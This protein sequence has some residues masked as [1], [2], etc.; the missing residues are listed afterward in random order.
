MVSPTTRT[1][2]YLNIQKAWS[3]NFSLSEQAAQDQRVSQAAA[4][5]DLPRSCGAVSNVFQGTWQHTYA[6]LIS[7]N[8]MTRGDKRLELCPHF[9]VHFSSPLSLLHFLFH[10]CSVV[11]CCISFPP[12]I[13]LYELAEFFTQLL[14]WDQWSTLGTEQNI[15]PG[16]RGRHN[17]LQQSPP[18]QFW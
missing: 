9:P 11:D 3:R 16:H 12:A 6:V 10:Q 14:A 13:I 18:K 5:L 1:L 15:E 4:L 2:Q 7:E 8:I 17:L